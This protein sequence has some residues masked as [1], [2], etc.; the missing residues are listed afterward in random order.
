MEG[1]IT[2]L[3]VA[4]LT[5]ATS[6]VSGQTVG[7]RDG[8]PLTTTFSYTGELV[9]NVAGGAGRGTTVPGVAGV[10][11]SLSLRR[12]AG[13]SGA[14]AFLFVLGTH[15]GAPSVLVGDAQG[16]SNLQAQPTLRL[17]EAWLQQN[18]FANRLSWLV[19][20]YDVNTEFYR[21]QSASLFL[22]SSFGIGPELS[23]SGGGRGPSIYPSTRFGTRLAFKPSRNSVWRAAVLDGP[24]LLSEVALLARQ[25]TVEQPRQRRFAIG[26]GQMRGYA[27]KLALGAWYYTG[28]FADLSDPT[29]H[30]GSAGAY[31]LGDVT[32]RSLSAFV[33]LGLGDGRVNQFG[34][35]VAAGL[36]LVGPIPSRAQ[37]VIG[38]AVAA[39]RNGS[40][41]E[42]AQSLAG[43]SAAAETAV[44]LT[45]LAQIGSWVGVQ[46][47]VQYV[48]HPGATR[49]LRNATVL[50]LR[51]AVSH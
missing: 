39:A 29:S 36:A 8:S 21:L 6:V 12:L 31:L 40:H 24:L 33:Q 14:R 18:L 10:Q 35:Y 22:N 7:P 50:G 4:A 45:Y 19:G 42:R 49:V 44:E 43:I 38:L 9:V 30:R 26:R 23:Q 51:V 46:P 11:A 48:I 1:A 20:R 16:V 47:D 2:R 15:G 5:I 41:F 17:E 3:A 13:W 32:L 37:D 25:D 34:G 28:Q 27:A